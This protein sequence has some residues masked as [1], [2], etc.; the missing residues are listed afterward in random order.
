[1]DSHRT[2]GVPRTIED[3]IAAVGLLEERYL[4]VDALCVVQDDDRARQAEINTMASI[5]SEATI[6]IVAKQGDDANYGLRGLCHYLTPEIGPMIF[7]G[8]QKDTMSCVPGRNRWGPL[9]G[10]KEA[11]PFKKG[12]FRDG[13]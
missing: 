4:W 11:G 1:M 6:S 9:S 13:S 3:A 8:Q 2:L 10:T 7:S 5:F 12:C